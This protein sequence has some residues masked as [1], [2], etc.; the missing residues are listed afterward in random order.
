MKGHHLPCLASQTHGGVAALWK[1]HWFPE[2]TAHQLKLSHHVFYQMLVR[3]LPTLTIHRLPTSH[4]PQDQTSTTGT[5][6]HSQQMAP[7]T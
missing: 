1:Q 4:T 7:V 2:Q 5:K 6:A 3:K